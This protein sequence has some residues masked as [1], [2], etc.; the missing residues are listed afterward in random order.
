M[1]PIPSCFR[2]AIDLD[3]LANHSEIYIYLHIVCKVR[4]MG[5]IT[6]I[7]VNKLASL[8]IL[9]N[10]SSHKERHINREFRRKV[11]SL[12]Q[13]NKHTMCT[14]TTLDLSTPYYINY[15]QSSPQISTS[16]QDIADI[17]DPRY[18]LGPPVTDPRSGKKFHRMF[19]NVFSRLI[20]S[21]LST[22][23]RSSSPRTLGTSVAWQFWRYVEAT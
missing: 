15:H 16:F 8:P 11:T 4:R 21:D 20:A 23:S 3:T 17:V 6:E 12:Q 18:V 14:F 1:F 13:F 7:M 22:G 2:S 9:R 5:S 10:G 19:R